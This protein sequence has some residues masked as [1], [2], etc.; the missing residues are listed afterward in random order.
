MPK[1]DKKVEVEARDLSPTN[2]AGAHR[3]IMGGPE[4]VDRAIE[5]GLGKIKATPDPTYDDTRRR[6]R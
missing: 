3:L 2:M 5:G 6:K 1:A 4:A